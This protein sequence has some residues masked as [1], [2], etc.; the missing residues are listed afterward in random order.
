MIAFFNLKKLMIARSK[1]VISFD[2]AGLTQTT[3]LVENWKIQ[4]KMF[5]GK[6][7]VKIIFIIHHFAIDA[8]SSCLVGDPLI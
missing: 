5:C 6:F 7:F 4:K 3:A 8:S 2:T 1:L